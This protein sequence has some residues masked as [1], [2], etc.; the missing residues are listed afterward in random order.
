[1]LP[2]KL[3]AE[4]HTIDHYEFGKT[5]VGDQIYEQDIVIMSDGFIWLGPED[6]HSGL[7]PE[8]EKVI[9]I[10]G[11][12]TLV[13]GTGADGNGT[14]WKKLIKIVRAEGPSLR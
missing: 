3:L 7:L 12:K 5:I 11:I 13:I 1:M 10:P 9:N 6:M 4:G 14:L 8:L 2:T